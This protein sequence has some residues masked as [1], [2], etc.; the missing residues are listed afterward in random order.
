MVGFGQSF[1]YDYV[2]EDL[3]LTGLSESNVT[4]HG[5]AILRMSTKHATCGVFTQAGFFGDANSLPMCHSSTLDV[6]GQRLFTLLVPDTV[7]GQQ[8]IGVIDLKAGKMTKTILEANLQ[9]NPNQLIGMQ[10]NEVSKSLVGVL[11]DYKGGLQLHSVDPLTGKWVV[12]PIDQ[13][14]RTGEK[15]FGILG[16][17]L[18][19]VMAFDRRGSGSIYVLVGSPPPSDDEE[20]ELHV[21]MIDVASSVLV[22]YPPLGK[23]GLG[24]LEQMAW[25]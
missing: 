1:D 3:V 13:S 15:P 21:A 5:H 20:P 23:V 6:S 4:G 17:N 19:T 10:W 24:L 11:P 22:K 16:G 18:G 12:S 7:Q 2:N 25:A 14:V 9:S 8:E